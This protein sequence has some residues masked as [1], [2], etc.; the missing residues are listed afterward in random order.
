MHRHVPLHTDIPRAARRLAA[1]VAL[2][3]PGALGAQ[4]ATQLVTLEV[5]A[6][7]QIAVSGNPGALVISTAAAGSAPTSATSSTTTWALTTNETNKKV[8]ASL[9][10][11][12]PSG[13]TL[14]LQLAAPGASASAGSVALGTS[15]VDL[16]TGIGT[17]NA[18]G[19]AVTYTLSAT[20]AAGV[21][22]S[23][24]RTVTLTLVTGS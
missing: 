3:V 23:T 15:A 13:V 12:L 8:T 18:S 5:Q 11:A 9:S 2:L 24:T 19:L 10:S 22:P 20:A 17:L 21:V 4:T 6:I 7:N 14:S 1:A 16:V